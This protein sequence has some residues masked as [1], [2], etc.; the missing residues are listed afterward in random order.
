MSEERLV[1]LNVNNACRSTGGC[2]TVA[3][4]NGSVAGEP[5]DVVAVI[6]GVP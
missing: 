1:V 6:D 5:S 2:I 3:R 4:S